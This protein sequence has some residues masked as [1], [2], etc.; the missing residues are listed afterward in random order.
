VIDLVRLLHVLAMATWLGSTLWMAGDAR[1]S[2]AAGPTEALAFLGRARAALLTDRAAGAV[3]ILSG[4]FLLHLAKAWPP[5]PGLL[6]GMV[7]AL[8]RAGLTDAV[9]APALR[10]I[11]TG[12]S[13]GETPASLAPVA[14]RMAAISGAGHLAW[15]L[16]LA[17]MVLR[18]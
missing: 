18:F 11:A 14:R 1:R 13:A 12:L 4:L 5:R 3:T 10:R 7:L 9:M 15:L 2:L 16:A 6:A 17:G 8:V